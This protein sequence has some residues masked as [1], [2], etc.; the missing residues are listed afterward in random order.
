LKERVRVTLQNSWREGR[1][2]KKL[3]RKYDEE[4]KF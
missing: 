3:W 2:W 1:F 4:Q